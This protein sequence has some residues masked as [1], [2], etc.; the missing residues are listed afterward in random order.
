M[1]R[2]VTTAL[3]SVL[4]L[5]GCEQVGETKR[6]IVW[7][8]PPLVS[9]GTTA[10]SQQLAPE[11][12]GK[13]PLNGKILEEKIVQNGNTA[14]QH[15]TVQSRSSAMLVEADVYAGLVRKGY[16]RQVKKDAG[17]VF[18]VDYVKQGDVTISAQYSPMKKADSTED[19]SQSKI[20]FTWKVSG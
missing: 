6:P 1:K 9:V 11:R 12:V 17:D 2:L 19:Q 4:L 8:A 20:V 3:A 16:A 5:V 18:A 13:A 7:R 14:F 10:I 15:Y